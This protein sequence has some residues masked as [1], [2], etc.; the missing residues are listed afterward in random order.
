M[1]IQ[2]W[3]SASQQGNV[4]VIGD[5]N[6]DHLKRAVPEHSH[7]NMVN[8]DKHEIETLGYTQLVHG[9]TRFWPQKADSLIDKCW[10]NNPDKVVHTLNIINGTTDH[11]LIE[12]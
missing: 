8:L 9:P 12:Q 10:T 7:L 3:I 4:T 6:L 1:F 5:T 11:N 2:Q